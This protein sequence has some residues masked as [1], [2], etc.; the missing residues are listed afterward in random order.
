MKKLF[1][2]VVILFYFS[3]A[4]F[5]Q[6]GDNQLYRYGNFSVD[7][8]AILDT[9]EDYVSLNFNLETVS[10]LK[11]GGEYHPNFRHGA[12]FGMSLFTVVSGDAPATSIVGVSLGYILGYEYQASKQL[13]F[14]PSIKPTLN[15][16]IF[17]DDSMD[18]SQIETDF[19]FSGLLGLEARYFFSEEG[20]YGVSAEALTSVDGGFGFL[21]GF[22]WRTV[23]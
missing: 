19:A 8:K 22:V 20:R 23:L 14:F 11:I 15:L 12:E 18:E 13:S 3:T 1:L 6:T 4:I 16:S 9:P 7:L 2:S 5:S 21:V 17:I 10:P